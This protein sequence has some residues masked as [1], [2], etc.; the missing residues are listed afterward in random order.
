MPK[1]GSIIEIHYVASVCTTDEAG[2]YDLSEREGDPEIYPNLPQVLQEDTEMRQK[3]NTTSCAPWDHV[4]LH[5][6]KILF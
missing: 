1:K 2:N 3:K 4:V 6:L 5:N